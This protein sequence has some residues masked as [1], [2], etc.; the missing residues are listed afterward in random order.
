MYTWKIRKSSYHAVLAGWSGVPPHNAP[1]KA[2]IGVA[3]A[4]AEQVDV[5]AGHD[6]I[7]LLIGRRHQP[8]CRPHGAQNGRAQPPVI[9]QTM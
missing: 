7:V 6:Y 3:H 2:V 4:G 8:H 5:Q 1:L 9:M